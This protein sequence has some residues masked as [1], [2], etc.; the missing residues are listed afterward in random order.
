MI[1]DN[2][3]H[4]AAVMYAEMLEAIEN[5]IGVSNI[6]T[7]LSLEDFTSENW[8][9]LQKCQASNV[10]LLMVMRTMIID[11][12][13]VLDDDALLAHIEAVVTS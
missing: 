7:Q 13:K 3:K 11:T 1:T 4:G 9:D 10:E 6:V 8:T 2:E 5:V 12:S